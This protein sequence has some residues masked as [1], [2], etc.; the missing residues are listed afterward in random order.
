M[1]LDFIMIFVL[2]ICFLLSWIFLLKLK[3]SE[4]K[5][6]FLWQMPYFAL[7]S[8]ALFCILATLSLIYLETTETEMIEN[9]AF[10][11]LLG[12]FSVLSA[13]FVDYIEKNIQFSKLFCPTDSPKITLPSKLES[14]NTYL[15]KEMDKKRA[16]RLFNDALKMG[17]EGLTITRQNPKEVVELYDLGSA[18][19]IWLTEVQNGKNLSPTDLEEMSYI[20]NDFVNHSKNAIILFD[21]FDYL[22][23]YNSFNKVLHLFQV[24]KDSISVKKAIFMVYINPNTVDAHSLKLMEAEFKSI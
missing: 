1:D 16:F 5:E 17:L 10:F 11:V 4:I 8:F 24:L 13:I 20:I 18:K 15:I 6:N 3:A 21:G 19:I 12:M 23:D 7:L 2:V 14:G 9:T 22:S